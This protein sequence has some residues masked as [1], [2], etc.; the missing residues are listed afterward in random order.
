M[1]Y[2]ITDALSDSILDAVKSSLDGGLMYLY[3]GPVPG[4]ASAALDMAAT[5]TELAVVSV[6]GAG[7]GLTFAAASSNELRKAGGEAWTGTAAFDGAGSSAPELDA[8]FFRFCAPGDNG[9]AAGEGVR[10]QGT[11]GLI[12][13]GSD[14]ERSTTAVAPDD[15]IE[16]RTFIVRVGSLG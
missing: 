5:H 1:S 4:E 14:M 9:R 8:A 3:A 2:K 12:G 13:S 16:I 10:L 15:V 6:D 11:I 7:T